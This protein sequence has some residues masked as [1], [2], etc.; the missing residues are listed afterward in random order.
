MEDELSLRERKKIETR[1]RI[2]YTAVQLFQDRGFEQTSVDEIA[3]QANVS[4]GTFFNYFPNKESVLHEI[5]M[6][7]LQELVQLVEVKLAGRSSAVDKIRQMMHRLVVDTL[8]Y[9]KITRYVLLGAILY[10]SDE[11][12]FNLRLSG[13]LIDLVRRA[14]AAGEIRPDLNAVE[15]THAITGPYLSVVFEQI[16]RQTTTAEAGAIVE[17]TIDLIFT[18]I[19]GPDYKG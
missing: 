12:A 19:A 2:L 14:Q 15:V 11:T 18:G 3:A 7:E 9:L 10:P 17:R 6:T 4:R 1:N 13:I 5:A 16:A 8:P